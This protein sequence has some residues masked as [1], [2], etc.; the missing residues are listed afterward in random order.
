MT[1]KLEGD[2]RADVAIVGGGFTGLSAALHLAEQGVGVAVLEAQEP[3]WGA[4]GRNGGQVN[5]G[6]KHDPDQIE[7]DFGEAMGR[8][9]V[10][11][12]ADAPNRVFELVQ[13]H[14]ITCEAKQSG[15]L[16]AAFT[17][18]SATGIRGLAAQCERRGMPVA[19][20]EREAVR[21]ATG[22]GRYINALLDRR[23]GFV[24][25]LGYARGLAQA[26]VQAGAKIHGDTQVTSI[27]Q[28]GRDWRL[29]AEGG[30]V[31]APHVIL[32]TNGYTGDL[33]P[34]LR[35]SI[36]P[37]FSGITATEPLSEALAARVMPSRSVLYEMESITTYYRLDAFNRLLMGGRSMMS[38]L[39]GP[40]GFGYLA[41]YA[42]RL[43]PE[44]GNISWTHGW[45]GQ[46][47][48]TTDHYPHFHEP[49]PGVLVCLGYNGRGVAMSTAMG[50]ELA[51][52]V[53]G[54]PVSELN[55]P[56][57]DL[58]EIP[59]HGLW[60]QAAVARVVYG[61]IRDSLGL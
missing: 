10:A 53:L 1:P 25:P 55:M 61:R 22:T 43:W 17:E 37:V 41:R 3:G 47:A 12:S 5:P 49:A 31:T 38:S 40:E 19:L 60:R 13:R 46:L 30:S 45:N 23:G 15:T 2:R 29:Q 9:M 42:V 27:R 54:T 32:A 35:R 28:V 33:W 34:G 26:A 7:R 50:A 8:R 18:R 59:F 57:T 20:L 56:V 24:N 44:L 51:R 4:S 21:E 39:S 6:L 36:V 58:R 16:R 11:F 48:V 52:R 14:Q